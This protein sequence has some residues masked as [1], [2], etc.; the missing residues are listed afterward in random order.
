L[1]FKEEQNQVIENYN[2]NVLAKRKHLMTF[3]T[4][5]G[6][7]ASKASQAKSKMKQ[8]ER[9][10]TIETAHPLSNVRIN[11]PNV[12]KKNAM[13]FRCH[14]LAI[15]YPEKIIASGI[16]MEFDQ[17]TH[18]AILGDNGQGKTT[19]MRTIAGLLD[20]K[21]GTFRWGHRL[22]TSYYGQHIFSVFDPN[23]DVY[24]CLSNM[25]AESVTRQEILNLAGSFLFKGNDILKKVA[26]L[27]G[28]EKARVCLAGL[29]LTK[30]EVL[31]LDEP[32]NHLDFETVE[33]LGRA[34]KAYHGTIFFISHD[35][36]FVNLLATDI[37]EIKEGKLERYPG[38]YEEYV[39]RMA[40]SVRSDLAE[41]TRSAGRPSTKKKSNKRLLRQLKAERVQ[42]NSKI[43]KLQACID[44]S[45]KEQE[46]IYQSYS[47]EKLSWSKEHHTRYKYLETTIRE[48]EDRWRLI[49]AR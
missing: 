44:N 6:A 15:G 27:S 32:T 25:A 46:A 13:A 21:H 18:I 40:A 3:V 14:D 28:G 8:I 23:N 5:F 20:K 33:A 22:K 17:G 35:R 36:T 9:L 24:T 42:L 39:Y 37:I 48:S 41:K 16:H 12:E 34:L 49:T 11:I 31:L 29:L 4:R 1:V 7:K 19:F 30:S 38:N 45:K 26:V 2:I 10:K 47:G 43:R